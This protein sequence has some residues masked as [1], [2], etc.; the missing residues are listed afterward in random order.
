MEKIQTWAAK[1]AKRRNAMRGKPRFGVMGAAALLAATIL[2]SGVLA[3]DR[4]ED[5][6]CDG[7]RDLRLVNGKIHTMDARNSIVSSVTIKRGRF[8]EIGRAGDFDDGG[9]VKTIDL[10]G[11]TAIPGLV[12]NHN[13][14]VL[15]K[16]PPGS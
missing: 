10:H 8:D 9:C 11:R 4:D 2:A 15:L 14:F 1:K 12:D 6:R 16:H 3:R 13:H 7:S 5:H